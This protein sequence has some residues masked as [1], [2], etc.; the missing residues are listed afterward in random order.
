MKQ[1]LLLLIS[2][3][4][5]TCV[6]AQNTLKGKITDENKQPVS[7]AT[8]TVKQKTKLQSITA[9]ADGSFEFTNLTNGVTNITVTALGFDIGLERLVLNGNK[10]INIELIT[11]STQL[12][13]VEVIGRTAKNT[14]VIILLALPVQL[15]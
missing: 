13:S 5:I 7:S 12:Q 2:L 10:E 3:F 8:V 4:T 14:T 9:G 1:K 15:F 6:Y 11:N